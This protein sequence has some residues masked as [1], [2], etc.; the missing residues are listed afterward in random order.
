MA[1]LTDAEFE[2]AEARGREKMKT[3]PRA[4][5]ARYDRETGRVVVELANGCTYMFPAPLAQE[6]HCA[7]DE[8]LSGVVIDGMGFNLH[9]SAINADLY[10]P[11]LSRACSARG[12]G[13]QRNGPARPGAQPLPRR[14]LPLARTAQRA[15]V[16]A[17]RPADGTVRNRVQ[18]HIYLYRP[19]PPPPRP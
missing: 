18:E 11:A 5:A 4:E 6:L 17:S 1:E 14:P 13:W 16:R 12:T 8:A 2:A 15:G 19:Y 3:E 9:W 7:D 10:V